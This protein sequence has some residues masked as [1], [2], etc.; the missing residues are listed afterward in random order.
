MIDDNKYHEKL[1][2]I[3]CVKKLYNTLKQIEV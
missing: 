3:F 1:I 2:K